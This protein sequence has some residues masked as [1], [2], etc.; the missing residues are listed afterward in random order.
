M[1]LTEDYLCKVKLIKAGNTQIK[2][3]EFI[4]DGLKIQLPFTGSKVTQ[5]YLKKETQ[6]IS[7]FIAKSFQMRY[8]V[9]DL[10]K[11]LFKYAKAPTDS[12]TNI[13]LKEI[14]DITLEADPLSTKPKDSGYN[15]SIQTSQR[16]YRM[17]ANTKVEQLMW[18]RAFTIL[19][20]LRARVSQNLKT[21]IDINEYLGIRPG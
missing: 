12:F 1:V 7:F 6:S 10:T 11:F 18:A 8:C 2:Q 21:T 13:H 14:I 16:V 9:L 3:M 15:F 5:G 19:F 20:E 4:M 17:Q